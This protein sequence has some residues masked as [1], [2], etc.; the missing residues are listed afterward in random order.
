[1]KLLH[2]ICLLL[3][4]LSL[5]AQSEQFK[6]PDYAEIEKRIS[7]EESEYYYP[8]LMPRFIA[9]DT[10]MSI[11]AKRHLY[12]GFR[13]QDNYSP[14]GNNEAEEEVKALF[15]KDSLSLQDFQEIMEISAKGL[16]EN[17]FNFRL[18]NVRLYAADTLSKSEEFRKVL[19]QYDIIVEAILSSGD[20]LTK[21]TA[22]YVI[23]V[24]HEY[25]LLNALG[26]NFGGKQST[27]ENRYDYLTLAENEYGIE[28]L[29]F[30]VSPSFDYLS[31]L[32][33]ED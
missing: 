15:R 23:S 8:R 10:T 3:L 16:Q 1:M 13:Y 22:Y 28:G 7:K 6:A 26:F 32:F 5:S 30:D 11:E 31:G 4:S 24:P 17:P 14:Y 25:A 29:Y 18:L 27:Y 9:G 12:Y 2:S 20:G 21:E 33:K 19:A